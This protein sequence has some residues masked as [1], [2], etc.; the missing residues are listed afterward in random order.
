[1]A[2][3]KCCIIIIIIIIISPFCEPGHKISSICH[4][5]GR[6]PWKSESAKECV[7]TQLSNQLALKMDGA[8]VERSRR[9]RRR[10][11]WHVGGGV[12]QG[13]PTGAE[14]WGGGYAPSPENFRFM[15]SKWWAFVHFGWYYLPF[16]CLFFTQKNGAFG[17]PKLKLTAACAHAEME[18][19]RDRERER[20]GRQSINK[21]LS[22]VQIILH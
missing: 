9:R 20:E 18:T 3:Y 12:P 13:L 5:T 16:S 22:K 8:E 4:C 1:M 21:N 10:W 6:W 15:I 2:L 14:A 11:G 17:L 19:D 7:T